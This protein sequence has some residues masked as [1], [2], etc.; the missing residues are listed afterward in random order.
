MTA[1]PARSVLW[2]CSAPVP[3]LL[4]QLGE[5]LVG[6]LRDPPEHLPVGHQRRGVLDDGVVLVVEAADEAALQQLP[7]DDALEVPL[8]LV[9][10][11]GRA[12]GPLGPDLEG[13]EEAHAPDLLDDRVPLRHPPQLAAEVPLEVLDVLEEPLALDNADVLER[14]RRRDRS[15]EHTSELQSRQYL[16]CRLLLEKK[17][18]LNIN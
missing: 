12:V 7:R 14:H 18:Y 10:L 8:V 15:E 16:V 5:G 4:L 6:D 11:Q 3:Q 13:P 1:R 2:V 17:K 9:A